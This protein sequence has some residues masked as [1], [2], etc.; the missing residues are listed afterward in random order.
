[1]T[2]DALKPFSVDA[3]AEL[4]EVDRKTV[5]ALAARGKIP[6]AL[7]LGRLLRFARPAVV[8]WLAEGDGTPRTPRR[9][10]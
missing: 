5:Y 2:E 1:V 7:R 8:A 9:T 3:L 10:R 4:L 6:G